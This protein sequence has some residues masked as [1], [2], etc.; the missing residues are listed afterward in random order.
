MAVSI[1]WLISIEKDMVTSSFCY[2]RKSAF[3]ALVLH[4]TSSNEDGRF[5]EGSDFKHPKPTYFLL[6]V[7]MADQTWGYFCIIS[8]TENSIAKTE[9]SKCLPLTCNLSNCVFSCFTIY[10]LWS[11][12][13]DLNIC[14]LRIY[15]NDSVTEIL[16][17][18]ASEPLPPVVNWTPKRL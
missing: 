14:S 10:K 6:A 15:V 2:D 18:Q 3:T 17:V 7:I 4:F 1:T 13:F 12:F 11:L 16:G 5:T 9:N 8:M